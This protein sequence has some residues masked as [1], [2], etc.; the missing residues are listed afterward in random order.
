MRPGS[1]LPFVVEVEDGKIAS[2]T[3]VR[4][5]PCGASWEAALKIVGLPVEEAAVRI[6]LDRD[7]RVALPALP[8]GHRE[9]G[10]PATSEM[11]PPIFILG[12]WRSGRSM[13]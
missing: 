4:G 5:A 12:H 8:E 13:G 2:V 9:W 7:V 1:A 6:G 10:L 3:V 11:A